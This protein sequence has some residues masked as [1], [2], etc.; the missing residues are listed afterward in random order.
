MEGNDLKLICMQD[1]VVEEVK[2]L[3][4]PYIPY[5]KITIVQGDPGDGKTNMIL[6]IA[7]AL[8]KGDALPMAKPQEPISVIYQTAE[9]G[10]G[11]TIKPRLLALDADCKRVVVIDESEHLLSL[12]DNRIEQAIVQSSAKL[13]IIDPLQAYLG[14]NVDMYRANE[15]RPIFKQLSLVAEKT[16]CAIVIIGHMNKGGSKS[17]YRGL[18]SIDITAAARSVLIVGRTPKDPN[19][20]AVAQIKSNLAPEGEAIAFELD[21]GFKWLGKWDVTVDELLSSSSSNKGEVIK[22]AENLLLTELADGAKA[23]KELEQKSYELGI[24]KRTLD[25]AKSNLQVKSVRIGTVWFWE[26]ESTEFKDAT[27]QMSI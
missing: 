22:K 4:Y 10:L 12:C 19:I 14:A 9:D 8:T 27:M 5:G 26:L 13:L 2:W 24:S 18:G 21:G 15:V 16:S 11:D 20:R 25:T 17:N 23:C 7:A 6:A 1:V 3:W